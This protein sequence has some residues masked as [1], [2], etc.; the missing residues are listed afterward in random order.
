MQSTID[1]KVRNYHIDR[2]G[3]V[4]HARYVAFLEE[5][6][7]QYLET[8]RLLEPNHRI[9][10]FHVVSKVLINYLRPVRLGDV[11]RIDAKIDGRSSRCF[12]VGQRAFIKASGKTAIKAVITNVVVDARGRPRAI[13][14]EM[15]RAWLDLSTAA[16][17]DRDGRI[18][19]NADSTGTD[20]SSPQLDS[21]SRS[22]AKDQA[23]PER[24]AGVLDVGVNEESALEILHRAHLKNKD[25]GS[26]QGG[27]L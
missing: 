16:I 5:A 23:G 2:F 24:D 19:C 4:N 10:A 18:R 3:H 7:W 17:K 8:N 1:I 15:L 25:Q 13:S 20:S 9:G 12:W 14:D 11:L 21:G 26:G 27:R 6:R 22:P